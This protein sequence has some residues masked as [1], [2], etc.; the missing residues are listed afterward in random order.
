VA[1]SQNTHNKDIYDGTL[2]FAT[3]QSGVSGVNQGDITVFDSTLNSSK[4]GARAVVPATGQSEMAHYIGISRQNSVLNSLNDVLL[5]VDVAFKNVYNLKTTAG[6]TYLHLQPVYWNETAD[7][8]TITNNTN[9]GARTVVVGYIILPQEFVMNGTL[10]IV[11]A[12]GILIPVAIVAH[13]PV[14][15][16]A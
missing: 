8:Q 13:T 4:G 1:Q 2:I 11:G 12:A 16:L 10:S 15:S 9:S 14:A 7:A 3:D 6:E 5:T